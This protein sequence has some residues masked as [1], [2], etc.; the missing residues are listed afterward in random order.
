MRVV[1]NRYSQTLEPRVYYVYIPHND[2]SRLP[3]FDT[4][5]SDLNLST[6][7][8]ENQ[9]AGGDRINDA[10]QV[11]I[12]LTS[13]L[14]DQKT[15][16]Q[17]LA[18]TVA[19][20]FY[21]TDQ[22]VVMPIIKNSDTP[23]TLQ[24]GTVRSG[25]HSD[26]F[27]LLSVN[28]INNWYADGAWQYDTD[29]GRTI[30]GNISTRY[31]PEAGKV[32]NLAYRFTRDNLVDAGQSGLE[33]I[34]VSSEWPMGGNWYGLGRLNYSLRDHPPTDRRG[35]VEYLAGLEYDAGCWQGRAVIHR[36]ATATAN[37]NY[38]IFFQLELGGLSSIGSN[39][40]DVL[41]RNIPGYTNTSLISDSSR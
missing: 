31:Q 13:R 24:S 2:Q 14:I 30:K 33:Q 35:P 6:L 18:A 20:R 38:A 36:L 27:A 32:L 39:P 17:R 3:V 28:L 23:N 8:T 21:Y 5:L 37:S 11:T 10:N 1:N 22:R 25:M 41:K 29:V 34:D 26:L 15:G 4:S 7:F 40:L 16:V 19:E 12:A 9:F